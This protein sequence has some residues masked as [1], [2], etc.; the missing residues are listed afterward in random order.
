MAAK[1][2]Q[3]HPSSLKYLQS[4]LNFPPARSYHRINLAFFSKFNSFHPLSELALRYRSLSFIAE[5]NTPA[6][7]AI[8]RVLLPSSRGNEN[9]LDL[10]QQSDIMYCLS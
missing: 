10:I 3:V 6:K 8:V 4:I 9:Q 2:E 1:H 5:H 7:R